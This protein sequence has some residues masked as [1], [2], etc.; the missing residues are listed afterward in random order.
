MDQRDVIAGAA[1]LVAA[2]AMPALPA[3]KL[4]RLVA[5]K[6]DLKFVPTLGV[7]LIG[8]SV[9]PTIMKNATEDRHCRRSAEIS[10]RGIGNLHLLLGGLPEARPARGGDAADI[11]GC[12]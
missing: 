6:A 12:A 7:S 2:A 11:R 1:T 8:R 3:P 4:A 10:A 5:A 9:V